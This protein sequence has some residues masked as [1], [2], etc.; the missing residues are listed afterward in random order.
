MEAKSPVR[1]M[2]LWGII[3]SWVGI[4]LQGALSGYEI[5][6]ETI[7]AFTDLLMEGGLMVAA[8]GRVI[9]SKRLGQ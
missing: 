6:K 4:K 3:V 9:A 1:S 7:D 2:T 5:P 8:I